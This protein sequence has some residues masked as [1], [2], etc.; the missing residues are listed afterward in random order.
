MLAT[1]DKTVTVMLA[2]NPLDKS[3]WELFDG[4][5]MDILSKEVAPRFGGRLPPAAKLYHNIIDEKHDVTPRNPDHLKHL[6]GLQGV[7]YVVNWPASPAQIGIQAGIFIVTAIIK[8]ELSR[9]LDEKVTSRDIPKGSPNNLPGQRQ[10]SARVLQRIPDIYGQVKCTPDQIQYP[11]ISYENNFQIETT[12]AVIGRGEFL[13]VE[14]QVFEGTSRISGIPGSS[15]AVYP[16]F[17]VPV[18][19]TPQLQIGNP[20]ADPLYNVVPVREVTG[21]N[22]LAPNNT[23]IFGEDDEPFESRDISDPNNV[24]PYRSTLFEYPSAG[25]GKITFDASHSGRTKGE[26]VE[27]FTHRL[28]TGDKFGLFWRGEPSGTAGAGAG[29]SYR[30]ALSVSST[31]LVQGAGGDGNIPRL[32][33]E[34]QTDDDDHYVVT[35]VSVIGVLVE[36]TI[37]VPASKQAEWAKIALYNPAGVGGDAPAGTVYNR[38]CV[39]YVLNYRLGPF[40]CNDPNMEKVHLNFIAERGL[41]VDNGKKQRAYGVIDIDVPTGSLG[42]VHIIVELTPADEDGVA[43]GAKELHDVYMYG[44]SS[45][46]DFIGLTS[47]ITPSFTG[48]FLVAVYRNTLQYWRN[49]ARSFFESRNN[50]TEENWEEAG[51]RISIDQNISPR[52]SSM[53][54]ADDIKWTHCYGMS[55]PKYYPFVDP[56][57]NF[58]NIT[59][60][61]SRT[62]QVKYAPAK[63]VVKNLNMIVNRIGPTWDGSAFTDTGGIVLSGRDVAFNVLSDYYIGNIDDVQIDYEGIADAFEEVSDAFGDAEAIEF[64]HTFDSEQASLEDILAAIGES[65]FVNFYRQGDIIK[66]I[67]DVSRDNSSLL[68]NHRNKLPGT[69]TRNNTFGTEEEYDGVELEYSDNADNQIKSYIAPLGLVPPRNPQKIRVAGVRTK[70]KAAMHAWRAAYRL[71]HQRV[72]TEF[73]SCEEASLALV[74]NKVLVADQTNPDVQ[75]GYITRIDGLTVYTSQEVSIGGVGQTFTLFIQDVDGSTQSIPVVAEDTAHSL[76]LDGAPSGTL[77]IDEDAGI[78]PRYFLVHDQDSTAQ[79]FHIK[80]TTYKN[81]GV[82]SVVATNYTEAYYFYDALRLWL[83]FKQLATFPPV[84]RF[85]DRSYK[86]WDATEVGSPNTVTDVLRGFV[87]DTASGSN[88]LEYQDFIHTPGGSVT[89]YTIACWIKTTAL[90]SSVIC[91]SLDPINRFI[92]NIDSGTGAFEVRHDSTI[93]LTGLSNVLNEWQHIGITYDSTTEIAVMYLDGEEISTAI[94]VVDIGGLFTGLR[95][96]N[97]IGRMDDFRFYHRPKSAQF[98]RELYR[99]HVMV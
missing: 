65:C 96:A 88:Y 47:I 54:Y 5:L 64:S 79:A 39:V 93:Y 35:S 89:G 83:T 43:S 46:R 99:K 16:P 74:M 7:V 52:T 72:I 86:E 2:L 60:V 38:C 42:G 13:V 19:G 90:T 6:S 70:G 77:V 80:E 41:W 9:F 23:Y 33:L 81:R 73:D 67:A 75:D 4:N 22:L 15:L 91:R 94:D 63:E 78:F 49:D 62:S 12:A 40:F 28:N 21:D 11:Y 57:D 36:Y 58:G 31:D 25:V 82:Y 1:I 32:T 30:G 51:L 17:E 45:K 14:S 26:G 59:I 97:I 50:R 66:A 29:L 87:F 10:N 56:V 48:R 76:I 8:W 24:D 71:L 68:F 53:T 55:E 34:P 85:S 3:T 27:Y 98:M 92:F 84:L 95:V 44:S 37:S 20:I 18:Y 69:E 61:H